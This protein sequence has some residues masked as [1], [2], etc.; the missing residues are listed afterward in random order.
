M[1]K[2]KKPENQMTYM[3]IGM[4]IGIGVGTA[5][6][7]A[8]DNI[9]VFMCLGL[10]IGLALGVAIDAIKKKNEKTDSEAGE[11]KEK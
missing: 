10:S 8:F 5:I 3:P 1:K 4:C 7:A 11:E 2:E 6:G 9:P